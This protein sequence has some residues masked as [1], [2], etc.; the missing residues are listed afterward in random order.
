MN[1]QRRP[2]VGPL[3]GFRGDG[4]AEG[5]GAPNPDQLQRYIDN[6]GF[7]QAHVPEEA[8]FFKPWNAAY[9]DWA[10]K[11]GLL[12]DAAALSVFDLVRTDAPLS[13]GGRGHG[14]APAARPSARTAETGDGPVAGLVSALWRCGRGVRLS[15]ARADPAADGHVSLLG[16]PERLAAPDP[17]AELRCICRQRSG[18]RRALQE[19]DW[20]RVSSRTGQ[21][22]VPVAHMAALNDEHGLDLERDRQA[23]GGLGAGRRTRP[24]RRWG[25]LLNHLISEL[26]P[27]QGRGRGCRIRTR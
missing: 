7:Y 18:R 12:R 25:F 15:G 17:G 27:R 9:Q 23:Q 20:A 10:V 6:G 2:G 1:H 8:A 21:I 4:T 16:Q 26:L 13:A 5:R 11:I 24:R 3:I 14:P 19:G 22:V